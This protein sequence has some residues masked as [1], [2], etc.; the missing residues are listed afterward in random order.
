MNI[1]EVGHQENFI[2]KNS[3]RQISQLDLTQLGLYRLDHMHIK[4]YHNRD[5]KAFS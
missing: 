2:L 1:P 5:W 3:I 4:F